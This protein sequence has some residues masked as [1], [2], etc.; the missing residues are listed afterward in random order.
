MRLQVNWRYFCGCC[1]NL[2]FMKSRALRQFALHDASGAE[3]VDRPN[4]ALSAAVIVLCLRS[5]AADGAA[6][7]E[8]RRAPRRRRAAA[9]EGRRPQAAGQVSRTMSP[10]DPCHRKNFQTID[11]PFSSRSRIGM[12]GGPTFAKVFCWGRV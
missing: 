4:S 6:S 12:G 3:R 9:Q 1:V 8:L 10:P 5:E 2:R 11:R 7:R